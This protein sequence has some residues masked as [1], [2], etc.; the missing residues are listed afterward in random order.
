MHKHTCFTCWW[1]LSGRSFIHSFLE[2]LKFY[3]PTNQETGIRI[4]T[5]TLQDSSPVQF[6]F[7]RHRFQFIISRY[8]VRRRL[9]TIKSLCGTRRIKLDKEFILLNREPIRNPT[10][11]VTK[12]KSCIIRVHIN[13]FEKL[14]CCNCELNRHY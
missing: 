6:L 7:N 4:Q 3:Y 8:R 11:F 9:D 13:A 10:Y 1:S 12:I 5:T 2:W 14:L